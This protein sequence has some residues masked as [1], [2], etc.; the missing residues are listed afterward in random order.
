MRRWCTRTALVTFP[1]F[2]LLALAA[3]PSPAR[4]DVTRVEVKARTPIADAGYEKIAG[5]VY[6]AVNPRTAGNSVIADLEKTATTHD[7][8]VEFSADFYILRPLDASRSNRVALVDVV[9]RGRK[10]VLSGFNRGGTSDPATAADLGDGFLMRQGF[11]VAWVGWEFDVRRSADVD[12]GAGMGI[13]VPTARGVSDVVRASFTPNDD[14]PQTVGDLAGYR[15]LDANARDT[16]L[17]V[18]DGE[19]GARQPIAR[20]RYT[21]RGNVVTLIGGFEKGRTYE[22]IYRPTE[23]PVAGLGLAAYRDFTSWLR[24][25]PD[26]LAP[27]DHTIGFG[28]SQSGRF[29]RTFFYYGF[30][31]DEQGRRVLDGAMV[32]IAGAAQLS[33]NQRGAQPTSL[34]MYAATQFPYATAAERDPVTRRVDGLFE[35]GRA[36]K[37]QPKVMFTNTAVE[38]WGGGRAAALIHTTADGKRDLTLPPNV[39]AYF[40][41][42]TQHGPAPFPAPPET[43]GQQAP[44]PLEY[45]WTMRALLVAMTDWVTRGVEPPASQVPRLSDGSLV[46]V[47]K[48][49]FPALPGVANP[50]TV[51][52]PRAENHDLPFLVPQVDADGN[53]IAGIR[54]PEHRVPMAT[55]TGWNFRG[56]AIGGTAQLVNLLGAAVPFPATKTAGDPRRALDERYPAKD[57]YLA[58]A[59]EAADALVK[60]RYL[61]RDDVAAVMARVEA[62]WALIHPAG[63][64]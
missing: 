25:A 22:L 35:N 52:G 64:R 38:Y 19:F 14:G 27:V 48:L 26:S 2:V 43:A 30:N 31:A 53:E 1:V 34:T 63:S 11:T 57:A 56:A 39:R 7:G 41:T 45:W 47:A 6:F 58:A 61:R 23:W 15:P 40:L 60:G 32:H 42:G 9:N 20:E 54:T 29:L 55:F 37:T 4:A 59:S 46:T 24:H 33:L 51:Q 12:R 21:V 50:R 5:L 13:A 3:S 62:W 10:M 36:A 18:R 16:T 44:N 17:S 49:K 8:R 28:S